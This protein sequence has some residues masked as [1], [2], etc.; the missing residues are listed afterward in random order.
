[1]I[2]LDTHELNGAK[3]R[4]IGVGGCGGNAVNNMITRNL[5]G[6]SFISANTDKQVLDTNLA[7]VKLQIGKETTKGLGAGGKPEIGELSAEEDTD[8]IKESLAGSDMIF[9]TAGMGGGTGTGAAP[10]VAKLAKE[11]N[12]LVVGIVTEPFIWEG[13]RSKIA[14]SGINKLREFVDALITIPNQKLID[15]TDKKVTFKQAMA[16]TDEVLFNATKGI[17]DIIVKPGL[18]NVDFA[19]VKAVM[20]D[21]GDAL[22]GIGTAIGDNRAEEATHAALNSPLLDNISIEGAKGI[23]INI[24]GNEDITTLHEV[25]AVVSI[26]QEAAGKDVLVYHGLVLVEEPM[27]EL[28][29]TVV[30]TGFNNHKYDKNFSAEKIN[31]KPQEKEL[32]FNRRRESNNRPS[33]N[34]NEETIRTDKVSANHMSPRGTNELKEF[35]VPA[36][37]R[38]I[39]NDVPNEIF[40]DRNAVEE[41]EKVP[42]N[43]DNEKMD[44]K[45]YDQPTFLRKIMD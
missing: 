17:S 7:Q 29:V 18:I 43:A 2:G 10:I 44:F 9:I 39:G 28:M 26:V 23:L 14:E 42:V 45:N 24:T 11:T 38:R 36:Y 33:S 27:D 4:V 20:Q 35:D 34:P 8:D 15:I 32:I 21:T 6:V 1:M 25:A 31:T 37:V 19:D 41:K 40:K 5:T 22:M 3:I 30:A 12:A 13:K 16:I